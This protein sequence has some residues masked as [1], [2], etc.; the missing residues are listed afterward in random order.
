MGNC[1]IDCCKCIEKKETQFNTIS[2]HSYIT[3]NSIYINK[4]KQLN[5]INISKILVHNNKKDDKN[6]LYA[7]E[8]EK[9]YSTKKYT[10]NTY[11][12]TNYKETSFKYSKKTTKDR[13]K[14]QNNRYIIIPD[15]LKRKEKITIIKNNKFNS[16]N[17]KEEDVE[18]NEI[19]SPL[20]CPRYLRTNFKN[21]KNSIYSKYFEN[22][23]DCRKNLELTQK[24]KNPQNNISNYFPI[25]YNY[26]RDK[27]ITY[28]TDDNF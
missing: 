16:E 15:N 28:F 22:I 13:F 11:S 24:V 20:I 7:L 2:N 8:D 23:E 26:Q 9:S 4:L 5:P 3:S 1:N 25:K 17:N 12:D 14:S 27:Y 18:I 21:S 10:E 6:N 19:K